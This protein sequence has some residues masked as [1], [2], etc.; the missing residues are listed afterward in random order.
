VLKNIILYF[1]RLSNNYLKPRD[2]YTSIY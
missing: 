1:N 2:I